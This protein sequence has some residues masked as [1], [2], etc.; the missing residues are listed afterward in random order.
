MVRL[1]DQVHKIMA[2]FYDQSEDLFKYHMEVEVNRHFT[3][4]NKL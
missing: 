3:L 4:K 2:N 1:G